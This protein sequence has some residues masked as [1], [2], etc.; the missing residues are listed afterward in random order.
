MV[1]FWQTVYDQKLTRGEQFPRVRRW[2]PKRM[3]HSWRAGDCLGREGRMRDA[4]SRRLLYPLPRYRP[5][6]KAV[7]RRRMQ[8]RRLES[9][10]SSECSLLCDYPG[11]QRKE[12]KGSRSG[13]ERCFKTWTTTTY[14]AY[15]T[16]NIYN[17]Y[18]S[19]L[20]TLI[21][22]LS[23]TH[24]VLLFCDHS[25]RQNLLR[26]GLERHVQSHLKRVV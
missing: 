19:N 20:S 11:R 25:K 14:T 22:F 26:L 4:L 8:R 13:E 21:S 2:S 23:F 5:H 18:H 17:T 3:M 15:S 10:L 1:V 7:Q 9:S 16:H 12:N 24:A 6:C